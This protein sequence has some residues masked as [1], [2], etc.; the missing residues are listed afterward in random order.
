VY[1]KSRNMLEAQGRRALHRLG[2]QH[3]TAIN[4]VRDKVTVACTLRFGRGFEP[5]YNSGRVDVLD[6]VSKRM[7]TFVLLVLHS[8]KVGLVPMTGF[9][10]VEDCP[11]SWQSSHRASQSFPIASSRWTLTWQVPDMGGPYFDWPKVFVSSILT[12]PSRVTLA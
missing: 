10:P 11:H 9:A 6:Q 7:D 1:F 5:K 8:Y 12:L 2:C 3:Q 4:C